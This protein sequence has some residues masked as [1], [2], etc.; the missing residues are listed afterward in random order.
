MNLIFITVGCTG[1]SGNL[2][3]GFTNATNT[4]NYIL[5]EEAGVF[6]LHEVNRWKDATSDA[7]GITTKCCNN[8]FWTSY[9]SAIMYTNFPADLPDYVIIC[10]G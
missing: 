10:D 3:E 7:L 2:T 6:H 1:N 4:F 9:N 8:Q 5:T